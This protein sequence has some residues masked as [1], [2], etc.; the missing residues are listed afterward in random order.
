MKRRLNGQRGMS[1]VEA[2][3]IL[4]VLS[5]LTAVLAPSIGD[6]VEEAK[7][8]KAKEDVEAI[9]TAIVRLTRDTGKPCLALTSGTAACTLANRA[10]L[11]IST[12][13]D[14]AIDTSTA[15]TYSFTVNNFGSAVARNWK[16]TGGTAPPNQSFLDDQFVSNN[17]ATP[18]S[19]P[20]F[21]LGGGPK[22]GLGWRGSYLSGPVGQDPWGFR[23]EAST[24]FL[25]VASNATGTTGEGEINA[26]WSSDVFVISAGSNGTLQ[27]PFGT[28]GSAAVGDDVTYVVQGAT[29]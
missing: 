12:G 5:V 20:N 18:Y 27:T 10:D 29:R 6:Y 28:L 13:N 22:A 25:T 2:T 15:T 16:G 9:G 24:V 4:M 21:T 7:N 11:L 8:T 23:Y 26:G 1:L 14:P 19:G 17:L 3:I